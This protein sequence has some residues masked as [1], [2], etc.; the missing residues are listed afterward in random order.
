MSPRKARIALRT[1]VVAWMVILVVVPISGLVLRALASGPAA[2]WG[3]VVDPV[4]LAALRLTFGT[5]ALAATINA[6][7]GT[8]IAWVLVRGKHPA[9]SAL[10]DIPFAVPTLVTGV[11][12]VALF[13]PQAWLGQV[14]IAVDTP[15]VFARPGIVLAMLFISLPLVVRTVEPV[16]SEL[17]PAEEDAAETL[18]ASR[19]QVFRHVLWPAMLPAVAAAWVQTFA[20]CIAEFGSIAALS[21]N[22]PRETLVA[23]VYILGELEAGHADAAAAIS[24]VLLVL[25]LGLQPAASALVERR[26]AR[27]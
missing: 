17:D 22:I 13:G 14:L 23:S 1:V 25:S 15:I 2:F 19:W 12:L 10:V 18:G 6:V 24:V 8:L 5:A 26:Y 11:V 20:R 7:G 27:V 16:L 4:A 3:Y 9:L 21:G